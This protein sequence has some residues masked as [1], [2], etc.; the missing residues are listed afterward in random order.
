MV[1][2]ATILVLQVHLILGGARLVLDLARRLCSGEAKGQGGSRALDE[3]CNV[4]E[5]F[6]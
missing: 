6:R 5:H 2:V 3:L 4:L 1:V